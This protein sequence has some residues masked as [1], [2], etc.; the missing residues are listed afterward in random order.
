MYNVNTNVIFI[1]FLVLYK[2]YEENIYD[3]STTSFNGCFQNSLS[4]ISNFLLWFVKAIYREFIFVRRRQHIPETFCF[5]ISCHQFFRFFSFIWFC[6]F[7]STKFRSSHQRCSI[8]KG[9]LKNFA[10]FTGKQLCQ[11]LFFNKVAACN[12]FKKRLWHRY[13]PV[14][15]AKFLE[16]LFYRTPLDDCFYKCKLFIFTFLIFNIF[17]NL[18]CIFFWKFAACSFPVYDWLKTPVLLHFHKK[19]HMIN[20]KSRALYDFL[21]II[22]D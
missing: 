9:V 2:S 12:V 14:N 6:L 1:W 15:F 11:G 22:Y 20:Q 10:K 3:K 21:K 19:S 8:K 4:D 7:Y 16:Y 17:W 5:L 18:L 13:F